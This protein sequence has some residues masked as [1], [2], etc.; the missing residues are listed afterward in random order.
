MNGWSKKTD[1]GKEE[2]RVNARLES[3]VNGRWKER[4]SEKRKG[5]MESG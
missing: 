4:I 1:R 2:A 3:L 5:W